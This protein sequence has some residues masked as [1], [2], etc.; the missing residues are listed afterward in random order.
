MQLHRPW[1][2]GVIATNILSGKHTD[3]D[4]IKQNKN[5]S[6]EQNLRFK[7]EIL[8]LKRLE[9]YDFP[10]LVTPEKGNFFLKAASNQ[11]VFTFN[12]AMGL[13]SPCFMEFLLSARTFAGRKKS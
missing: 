5:N 1:C 9:F 2:Y 3:I 7:P 10:G 11:L 13:I 6:S 8:L 4:I 12:E